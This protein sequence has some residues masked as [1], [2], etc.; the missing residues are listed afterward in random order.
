MAE[1]QHWHLVIYDIRDDKRWARAYKILKGRGERI[2]YS[3]FRVRVTRAQLE[4]LRWKLK[5]VMADEDDL[6]I[7][8]LCQGCAQRVVDSRGDEAWRKPM[9]RF[10][11]F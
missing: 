10:E 1:E 5:Q 9:P 11:V 4:E 8:R 3:V 6:L 7:V 2:Q